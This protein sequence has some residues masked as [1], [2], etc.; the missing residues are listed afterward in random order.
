MWIRR[1]AGQ[2]AILNSTSKYE[3]FKIPTLERLE[4]QDDREV[5]RAD[6]ILGSKK[7]QGADRKVWRK[8]QEPKEPKIYKK[9]IQNIR[10]FCSNIYFILPEY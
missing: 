6:K 7:R 1:R 2:G 9:K 4:E 10:K 5:R 3:R 8:E